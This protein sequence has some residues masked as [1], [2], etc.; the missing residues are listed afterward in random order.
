VA[1]DNDSRQEINRLVHRS[2][3]DGGKLAGGDHRV[4]VLTN[5]QELTGADRQWAARYEIDDVVRYTRQ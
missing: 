2:L 4:T 3:R 5:R 1:P